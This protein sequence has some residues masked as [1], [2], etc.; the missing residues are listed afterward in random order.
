MI[1]FKH[2]GSFKNTEHIL[3]KKK[4]YSQIFH[5]YGRLGVQALSQATP[6]DTG[7]TSRSWKYDIVESKGYTKLIWSNTNLTTNGIPVAILLQY[8]HATRSGSY[9]QGQ[10]F[11]N[12]ALKH[13][14]DELANELWKEVID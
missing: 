8:G 9:I 11:I 4:N 6:V 13:I 10:D 14:F 3:N 5:K 1:S 2:R 7:E 12:P